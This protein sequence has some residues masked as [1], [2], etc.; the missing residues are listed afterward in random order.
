MSIY[1]FL[2]PCNLL[3]Q[4]TNYVWQ[5][6]IFTSEELDRIEKIGDALKSSE[7][8]AGN[9]NNQI[10]TNLDVRKCKVAWMANTPE[11]EFVY[12]KLAEYINFANAKYYDFDLFGFVEDFQY[13][14]YDGS[15]S[16]YGWH[17][18]MPASGN[19]PY[20]KLSFVL[21][22]SD[23]ADYEGGNLE[24]YTSSKPTCMEKKR[25][26]SHLFPSYLLHRVTPVTKGIRKTLVVWVNGNRFK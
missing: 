1:Q 4:H 6:G 16:H 13:T 21:Q 3:T 2:P 5:E 7:G 10:E 8:K 22:L 11:T 9:K 23:P 19:M 20:R 15:E 14:V 25:G 24:L 12:N 26:I 17:L 18:D